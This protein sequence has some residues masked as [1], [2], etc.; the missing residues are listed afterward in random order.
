MDR[1]EKLVDLTDVFCK[2][3]AEWNGPSAVMGSSTVQVQI[4]L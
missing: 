2:E 1:H 3:P 4:Y